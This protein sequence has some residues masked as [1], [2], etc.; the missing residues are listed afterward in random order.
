M[1]GPLG[2]LFHVDP[3]NEV[4]VVNYYMYNRHMFY[5]LKKSILHIS[6]RTSLNGIRTH[7][8]QFTA[9]VQCTMAS[10]HNYCKTSYCLCEQPLSSYSSFPCRGSK[11]I[12]KTAGGLACA[13]CGTN[14]KDS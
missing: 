11:V 6:K 8:L 1:Q 14:Y 12:S 3:L 4:Y 5:R 9:L 13:W 10:V 2:S 7:S